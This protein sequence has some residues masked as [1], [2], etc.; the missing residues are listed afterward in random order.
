MVCS[1]LIV[2]SQ[3]S[4]NKTVRKDSLHSEMASTVQMQMQYP[5]QNP[6]SPTS[7]DILTHLWEWILKSSQGMARKPRGD[8]Y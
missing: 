5:E 7:H 8:R 2:S 3:F 1:S 6:S 4:L